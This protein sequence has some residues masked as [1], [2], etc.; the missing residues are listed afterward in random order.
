ML[1]TRSFSLPVDLPPRPRKASATPPSEGGELFDPDLAKPPLEGG[2][3]FVDGLLLKQISNDFQS[4]VA[5]L[6]CP[7]LL[8][9]ETLLPRPE[10]QILSTSHPPLLSFL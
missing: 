2:E 3:L 9:E 4:G 8:I 1:A 10:R 6:R 5:K 7:L